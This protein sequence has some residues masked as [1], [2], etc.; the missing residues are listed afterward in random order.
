MIKQNCSRCK[1]RSFPI[2]PQI[3]N[4][5]NSDSPKIYSGKIPDSPKIYT[6]NLYSISNL[7]VI[8]QFVFLFLLQIILP[9]FL[10]CYVSFLFLTLYLMTSASFHACTCL[11]PLRSGHWMS[12]SETTIF[13]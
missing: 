13:S 10:R 9:P 11:M 6:D 12:S 3:Q 8:T 1:D 2:L 4:A 5:E 7:W